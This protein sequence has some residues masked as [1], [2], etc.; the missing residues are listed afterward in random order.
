MKRKDIK[1]K[2]NASNISVRIKEA[3]NQKDWGE[4][5][6]ILDNSTEKDLNSLKSIL[7]TLITHHQWIVRASTI[8]VIG[9]FRLLYFAD[10]VKDR[11]QDKNSV[12]KSYA[13]MAYYDLKKSKA[14]PFIKEF[15]EAK[16]VGIRVTALALFFIETGD[17]IAFKKLSRIL[18]RKR[19]HP[20][21]RC[22]AIHIFDFYLD[23]RH[24]SE[25]RA[26]FENILLNIPKPQGL[27]K[28]IQKI[29]KDWKQLK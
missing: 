25:I 12:V 17:K 11:L 10:I 9:D 19:C 14:L 26:L 22:S 1:R 7:P 6:D 29:L 15:C 20:K 8:E 23:I 3:E 18:I 28:Y 4:V 13:L 24:H 21:H 16:D 27:D 5:S 2:K